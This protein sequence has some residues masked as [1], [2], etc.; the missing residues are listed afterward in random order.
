MTRT[1]EKKEVKRA[2]G[3]V[4]EREAEELSRLSSSE[5]NRS[6]RLFD[7]EGIEEG[8]SDRWH[9][10]VVHPDGKCSLRDGGFEIHVE[11]IPHQHM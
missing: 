11:K 5:G 4:A 6:L 2:F 10:A 3:A 1:L 8:F 9:M 7:D